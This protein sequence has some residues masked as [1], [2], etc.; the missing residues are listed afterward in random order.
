ME[1]RVYYENFTPWGLVF[2]MRLSTRC[3]NNVYTQQQIDF[4]IRRL[5]QQALSVSATVT[6]HNND[7]PY[8]IKIVEKKPALFAEE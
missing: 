2:N 6:H 8:N 3:R 5:Q 7:K 4:V 1:N